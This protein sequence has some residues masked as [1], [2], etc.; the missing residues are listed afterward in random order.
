LIQIERNFDLLGIET[1]SIHL[2]LYGLVCNRTSP[3]G[4]E[5]ERCCPDEPVTKMGGEGEHRTLADVPDEPA[6][7][8]GEGELSALAWRASLPHSVEK[9]A[10]IE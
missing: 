6:T 7:E 2:N 3:D 9:R 8:M 1:L 10:E 5:S 4:K